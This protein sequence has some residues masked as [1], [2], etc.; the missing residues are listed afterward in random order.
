MHYSSYDDSTYEKWI[1]PSY[2]ETVALEF[3]GGNGMS[4]ES[5]YV[6]STPAHIFKLS[7]DV[8]KGL[9]YSGT[10]FRLAND[11][12]MG[13][14]DLRPIGYCTGPFDKREFCGIFDGDG[15]VIRNFQMA[16]GGDRSVGVFGYVEYADIR[17]LGVGNFRM[18]GES[19]VGAVVGYAEMSTITNCHA[20]GT[21]EVSGVNIGGIAGIACECVIS[22]CSAN[23]TV[24]VNGGNG[25][26]GLCGYVY[27]NSSL[28]GCRTFGEVRAANSSD[29]AGFVGSIKDST[30]LDCESHG[31][32]KGNNCN[33]TGGFGGMMRN[34][35]LAD[36]RAYAEVNG[37]NDLLYGFVG[38]FAG[39]AN[40]SV[41]T[42]CLAAGY[43]KKV[44]GRGSAG[45]FIGDAMK[46]EIELSYA[47]GDVAAEGWVGGFAG[48]AN[49][50]EGASARFENCYAVGRVHSES[51]ASLTAGFIGKI[52]RDGG[53][54]SLARCYAYGE[55]SANGQGFVAGNHAGKI[56]SCFWRKDEGANNEIEDRFDLPYL[57]VNEFGSV[58]AFI[59]YEWDIGGSS[60][61]WSLAE[62]SGHRRPHLNGVPLVG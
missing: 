48:S 37:L 62:V 53:R 6:I 36:C 42:R 60:C 9:S 16:S 30:L 40:N 55:V 20:E 27:N 46:C 49:C 13:G 2:K 38:G 5:A 57:S 43:V 19:S 45:G 8:D 41:F 58:I 18:T 34:C 25:V 44:G 14:L 24:Q 21:I 54:V 56:E 23:V 59:E 31:A 10:Y 3:G 26:G 17:N 12:D 47:S 7:E 35:S 50:V 39:Y 11:I 1:V 51:S 29:V 4:P 52:E 32:V 28:T 15:H 22:N 61:I 33:N